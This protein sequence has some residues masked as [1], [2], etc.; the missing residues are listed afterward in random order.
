MGNFFVL[1]SIPSWPSMA[2]RIGLG[3]RYE[4]FFMNMCFAMSFVHMP[5]VILYL[6]VFHT[7]FMELD[8]FISAIASNYI[9]MIWDECSC[10]ILWSDVPVIWIVKACITISSFF[11]FQ[12]AMCG[13]EAI[14]YCCWNT[15]YCDYPCQQ[16][17]WPNH[18]K[19]CA[20]IAKDE[21]GGDKKQQSSSSQQNSGS[22]SNNEVR[23]ISLYSAA[24]FHAY[25]LRS[26]RR[27]IMSLDF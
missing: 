27:M 12:C 15:S 23:H 26:K 24:K 22:V 9:M 13:K 16:K 2:S 1:F 21:G 25:H 5:L 19:T 14:F 3:G 4:V 17:H 18:L 8:T 10:P 11:G 20:Q 6:L 7:L